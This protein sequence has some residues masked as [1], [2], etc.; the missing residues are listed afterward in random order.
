[1]NSVSLR[2]VPIREEQCLLIARARSHTARSPILRGRDPAASTKLWQLSLSRLLHRHDSSAARNI[3]YGRTRGF[4]EFSSCYE[5]LKVLVFVLNFN[6]YMHFGKPENNKTSSPA[7][8]A[9]SLVAN[10]FKLLISDF[11]F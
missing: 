10:Q 2:V 9:L 3:F 5:M 6:K 11:L 8:V 1:M 7:A 4:T